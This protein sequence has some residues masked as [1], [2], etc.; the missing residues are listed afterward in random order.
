[1]KTTAKT[2]DMKA[3]MSDYMKTYREN[4]KDKLYDKI[5]CEICGGIY[6]KTNKSHHFKTKTHQFEVL[7][8]KL[9]ELQS[10]KETSEEDDK[11][12]NQEKNN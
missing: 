11:S 7:K 4:N 5:R 3:Y 2:T 9:D 1:M 12:D 6:M 8:I 10:E